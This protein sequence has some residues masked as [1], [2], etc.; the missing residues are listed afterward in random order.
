MTEEL[1]PDGEIKLGNGWFT[2]KQIAWV[3]AH[4]FL[5]IIEEWE[6]GVDM[7]PVINFGNWYG[8]EEDVYVEKMTFYYNYF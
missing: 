3:I 8:I 4:G 1:F 5:C 7:P 6:E 2:N